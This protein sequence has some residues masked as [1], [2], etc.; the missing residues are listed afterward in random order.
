M[1]DVQKNLDL[2]IK[3]MS[4]LQ[5]GN[6]DSPFLTCKTLVVISAQTSLIF[7]VMKRQALSNFTGKILTCTMIE[8]YHE[9]NKKRIP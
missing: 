3:I 1:L 6:I 5:Q 2:I 7:E 9:T 8:S 4:N